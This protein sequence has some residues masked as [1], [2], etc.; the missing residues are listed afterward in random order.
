[1]KMGHAL[2]I[3][4]SPAKARTIKKFLGR[5]FEVKACMGHIKD[6]PQ[7][8]LGVDV[9]DGYRP[10]YTI[11]KGK[12]KIIKELRTSAKKADAIFLAPDPDREGE[13][14]AWHVAQELG[15]EQEKIHRILFNEITKKA[16]SAAVQEP[17]SIDMRLVNAQQARRIMDRLVGYKVS[18][19]L[20]RTLYSGL[21]AGRVQSVALRLVCEREELIEKFVPQ[22]YWSIAAN[23]K[24]KEGGPFVALLATIDGQKAV[25]PDQDRARAIVEFLQDKPFTVIKVEQKQQTKNPPPPFIT[26]SLQQDAARALR[27]NVQ[28]TMRVAQQLY[29]G[30]DIGQ[31]SPVGLI[32]YMRTDAPRV[33]Q[34]A[35]DEVR[36]FIET[37]FGEKYLPPQP[38]RYKSKR[39][40]QEAHEAIR[41]TSVS[42]RPE[43]L[44]P[45]LDQAQYGL[46][47]LIWKRFVASQMKSAL[48]DVTK[49]EV[50]ADGH[51]FRATGSVPIFDGFLLIY[52]ESKEEKIEEKEDAQREAVLPPLSKGEQL[53]LLSLTPEQ[54]FTKPPPRY[55]EATLVRALETEGIGRPS[56]YAQIIITLKARKYVH[57]ESRRL[58]P[59]DLGK[60]V[61]KLLV[62]NFPDIFGVKFT[63]QMEEELDRVEMGEYQWVEV[64]DDFYQPFSRV[65]EEA[66]RKKADLKSSLQESTDEKCQ[67]CGGTMVVKWGRNGRFMACDNFPKC[68]NTKP[69]PGEEPEV[70]TDEV[71][72]RCGS[73]MVIK[74]GRFGRFLACSNYPQCRNTKP[75]RIGVRCFQENCPGHVVERKTKSGRLFYGCS[76]YPACAFAS[77]DK[78]VDLACPQCGARP[79]VEKQTKAKGKFYRCRQCKGEASPE[80]VE[81]GS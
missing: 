9:A 73:P 26:S 77:W 49:V 37:Q 65:L 32:T 35:L 28:K 18:P 50:E 81:G 61:S 23:L 54:H 78:P 15:V 34:E 43:D 29:E 17:R 51:T 16:V 56:T 38:R 47:E 1:M 8:D 7:K 41:P 79:M 10:R 80:E 14:I 70:A 69:L 67:K 2:V 4:E 52:Q 22:E 31:Q 25:I 53:K 30:L 63:A 39:G 11:I 58:M 45:H 62:Q 66:N 20:W 76:Q 13:A 71:C 27:F 75:L 55:T 5:D 64:L 36:Q 74:T 44:K 46:Y 6:L 40:A 33:A 60:T 48:F 19:F 21:S 57:T 3:V 68:R 42:R 72:D 12:R 59:T 24:G